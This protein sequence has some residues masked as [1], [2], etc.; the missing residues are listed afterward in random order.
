MEVVEPD[1]KF[2]AAHNTQNI[3]VVRETMLKNLQCLVIAKLKMLNNYLRQR[4]KALPAFIGPYA[5][6]KVE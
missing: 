1:K 6:I 2:L 3:I 5:K 4:D